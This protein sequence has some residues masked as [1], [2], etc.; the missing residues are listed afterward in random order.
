MSTY[1]STRPVGMNRSG[2]LAA[3]LLL[4][5]SKCTSAGK[6]IELVNTRR[7]PVAFNALS[8]PSCVRYVHYYE[9]LLCSPQ[10]LLRTYRVTHVRITTVPSVTAEI[11]NCGC[12]PHLSLSVLARSQSDEGAW[13]PRR[14]YQTEHLGFHKKLPRYSSAHD[15]V[16]DFSLGAQKV[17]VRGDVCLSVF[18][19]GEKISQL[20]FH[21]SFVQHNCLTFEK[22]C[23]DIA[24]EDRLHYTFAA[25]YKIELVLQQ[26]PDDPTLNLIQQPV[27]SGHRH[28][29]EDYPTGDAAAFIYSYGD[30]NID[31]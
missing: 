4:H 29:K 31:E 7:A 6:A 12:I 24:A 27:R 26:I 15:K 25:G 3:C 28:Q 19:E 21:T 5:S 16:M 23:I 14:V 2:L 20:Y 13:F 10:L 22:D 30:T 18:S 9:A 17:A 1:L 8:M 11:V